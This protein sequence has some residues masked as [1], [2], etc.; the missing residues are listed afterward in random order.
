MGEEKDVAGV[1][2][3]PPLIF[4]VPLVIGLVL[5]SLDLGL[6]FTELW[7]VRAIGGGA[8]AVLGATFIVLALLRFR[9]A[10]TPPQPW[11]ETRAIVTSG[12]YKVTRNPMYLGMAL[13]FLGIALIAGCYL[14]L[15][16]LG[17]AVVTVD[18]G[19]IAREE[20]YLTRKFGAAYT[21]YRKDS[22][23]WL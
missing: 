7:P 5:H 3:P 19:V 1:L 23:R 10:D 9:R 22:R 13:I 2:A 6:D 12:V 20:A 4:G 21:D 11:E 8:L 18:R 17:L 16:L 14:M 15:A